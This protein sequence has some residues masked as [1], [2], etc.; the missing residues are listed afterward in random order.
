M[1][2][3]ERPT[4]MLGAVKFCLSKTRASWN[5][6]WRGAIC[7]LTLSLYSPISTCPCWIPPKRSFQTG[8]QTQIISCGLGRFFKYRLDNFC[9]VLSVTYPKVHLRKAEDTCWAVTIPRQKNPKNC[10]TVVV[11]SCKGSFSLKQRGWPQVALWIWHD[12]PRQKTPL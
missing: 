7:F 12:C 9:L 10:S 8:F 11:S 3:K 4:G 5:T 6:N 1:E 2:I